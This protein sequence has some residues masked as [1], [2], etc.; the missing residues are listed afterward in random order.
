[1]QEFDVAFHHINDGVGQSDRPLRQRRFRHGG[2]ASVPASVHVH[3]VH[4]GR[5]ARHAVSSTHYH[6]EVNSSL[7]T[8]G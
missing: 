6:F 4:G 5:L 8:V 2:A 3:R 1:M 7:I